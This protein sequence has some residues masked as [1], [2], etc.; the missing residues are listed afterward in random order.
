M[1]T[2]APGYT[3]TSGY[4]SNVLSLADF[5]AGCFTSPTNIVEGDP[6]RQ[7]FENTFSLFAQDA[8]QLTH[9]LNFNYGLRYDYSGPPYGQYH[10]LTSFDP[11]APNG[12]AV[13][14]VNIP[15]IYQQYWTSFSPRVGF[16]YQPEGYKDTVIRG[17]FGM[18]YDAPYMVP[19]LNLRGTQN[20]GPV[21]VQ[22]NPA[23]VNPVANA[24]PQ[25]GVNVWSPGTLIFTPL[26]EA[27]A[28]AGV[29]NLYSVNQ[30]FRPSY[31]YSYNLNVQQSFGPNIITQIGYVG[32]SAHHLIDV[33]DI[34]QAALNSGNVSIDVN[35][36]TYQQ[37]TRPYFSQYPNYAVINQ[38]ESEANSNYNSLQALIRTTNWHNITTQL[39]YT[40]SHSL[41]EETGLVPYPPQN[42]YDLHGEYGNSDFDVTNTFTAYASYDVPGSSH[43]PKWLSN[44]WQ[45]HSLLS[46]HGGLPFSVTASHE[47]SGNGES[48]DRAN[49]IGN[50]FAGVNHSI[51]DGS[52]QWFIPPHS[53]IRH[54][55]L[56]APAGA[57][58][59][60]IQGFRTSISPSSRTQ[61]SR[62][63]SRFNCA[64]RCSISSTISTW[65]LPA[66]L[67]RATRGVRSA[68]PSGLTSARRA[69]VRVSRSIVSWRERL[70]SSW[71]TLDVQLALNIPL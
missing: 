18:F 37:T 46:F 14:G 54:W 43:G 50:P 66:S 40:W 4:D 59:I 45:L 58:S 8:W 5:L 28:G 27:I 64:R 36:Y 17:G 26:A 23:G 71:S 20:G 29:I 31:T 63:G 55:A 21:G 52:V 7:V 68:Q 1:G 62:S 13:A 35:Q 51:V 53:K 42:S 49:Q 3:P 48:A 2:T 19:F 61:K 70:S 38:V 69:S 32:F 25:P 39:T 41:D 12:I 60:G 56:T 65:R 22:E 34:N 15:N 6:K 47:N 30:N 16:A 10:D 57:A 33:R 24:N 11:T 44:G 9:R 67:R